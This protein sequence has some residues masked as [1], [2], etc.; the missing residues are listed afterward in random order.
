MYWLPVEE[1]APALKV[2]LAIK[3]CVV[4]LSLAIFYFGIFP[5]SILNML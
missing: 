3:V 4:V 5:Q 2:S 1:G